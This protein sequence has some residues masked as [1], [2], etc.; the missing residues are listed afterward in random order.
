MRFISILEIIALIFSE[1]EL[2]YP[3]KFQFMFSKIISFQ[4]SF[5]SV[6]LVF[7]VAC[8]LFSCETDSEGFNSTGSATLKA[9]NTPAF[10]GKTDLASYPKSVQKSFYQAWNDYVNG[11]TENAINVGLSPENT[12]S[13]PGPYYFN[14][15]KEN[16]DS[17]SL[18]VP[19]R[20]NSFPYRIRFY[21]ADQLANLFQQDSF[22][23]GDTYY[24]MSNYALYELA[25]MGPQN[26]KKKYPTFDINVV[27]TNLCGNIKFGDQP[28][29]PVGPR[30]WLDE[31]NEFSVN[32]DDSGEIIS[33]MFTSE[34]P[35]YYWTLWSVSPEAVLDIYRKTLNNPNIPL[36]DLYLKAD[37]E[38]VTTPTGYAYNPINKWNSGTVMG[39]NGGGA[40]HLTSS[41]NELSAE[42]VLAAGAC[43]PRPNTGADANNAIA[44]DLICCSQ[45]GRR[46][47][48]SDPHIGQSVNQAISNG[49]LKL[50]GTLLNPV[51]LYMQ[52]PNFDVY[53]L[54]DEL[55][56]KGYSFKDCWHILRGD[57]SSDYYP[58]S[59]ILRAEFRIPEEWNIKA[60][61]ITVAG[62]PLLF[63]SQISE[64]VEVQLVAVSKTMTSAAPIQSCVVERTTSLPAIDLAMNR[65]TYE[66]FVASGVDTMSNF[67]S[68]PVTLSP[69]SSQENIYV[70]L[71]GFDANQTEFDLEF[72]DTNTGDREAISFETKTVT[73]QQFEG[74][75]A[76]FLLGTIM[77]AENVDPGSIAVQVVNRQNSS[78]STAI[79]PAFFRVN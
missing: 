67:S 73:R 69:N 72:F 23:V 79:T 15:L 41:P 45:Y 60:S 7:C 13:L 26:F 21:Y 64:T 71:S 25:E 22:K 63:A 8:L 24:Q 1:T 53:S 40:I 51:G 68:N 46:F 17:P 16:P 52:L 33:A 14:P 19:V 34:N 58:N 50:A 38:Y 65:A 12:N 62:N 31:Y 66:G 57:A 28:F 44:N 2:I 30:G 35:E 39:E 74:E 36:E 5:K 70:I 61:D 75:P 48:N 77:A 9:F 54:P 76:T 78:Q 42:I 55:E 18:T 32:K 10:I 59:T 4:E 56:E 37:G 43:I 47:R 11:W 29:T 27:P 20:W 3:I 49:D 6:F